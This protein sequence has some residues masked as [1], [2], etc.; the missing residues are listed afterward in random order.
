[1]EAYQYQPLPR[2]TIGR[3]APQY[4]RLMTLLPGS[5]TDSI[6][7]SLEIVDIENAPPFEALSYV[8]GRDP[9]NTPVL[10]DHKPIHTKWNLE[11]ALRNLRCRNKSR[12]LWID[13]VC[14]DQGSLSERSRQV[15]YMSKIYKNASGV[16]VWLG[17]KKL[18]VEQAFEFASHLVQLQSQ[19]FS[20]PGAAYVK[21]DQD[22]T[23]RYHPDSFP[24]MMAEL[25]SK[26][27]LTGYLIDIFAREYFERVWCIQEVLSSTKCTAKCEDLEMDF[28]ELVEV[29]LYV[30][31]FKELNAQS[32]W[33]LFSRQFWTAVSGMRPRQTS[34]LFSQTV[35]GSSGALLDLLLGTRDFKSTDP[36]DKVYALLGISDEGLRPAFAETRG[37]GVE[38]TWFTAFRKVR[39]WGMEQID[40]LYPSSGLISRA[41]LVPD[42]EK[43][44]KEVY[45]N[46]TSYFIDQGDRILDVLS[47]VQHSEDPERN[48]F[49]SWV[50]DW[51]K[52]RSVSIMAEKGF[53]VG[54]CRKARM[55]FDAEVYIDRDDPDFIGLNGFPLDEVEKV[56]DILRFTPSDPLP[57]EEIWRNLFDLPLFP[58]PNLRYR[59]TDERLDHAFFMTLNLSPMG[60][61]NTAIY[62][63]A[64]TDDPGKHGLDICARHIKENCAAWLDQN[65][66]A[67]L[68]MYPDLTSH[69]RETKG[70]ASS[71]VR[72]AA[73]FCTNRRFF[74]TKTGYLGIGPSVIRA[75]DHVCVLF[76]GR[77]PFVLRSSGK[78][79]LLI[80]EAYLYD[81]ELLRGETVEAVRS[82]TSGFKVQMYGLK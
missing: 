45:R 70:S 8:W 77:L 57:A 43:S 64:S 20:M 74:I 46:L 41:A 3:Y 27:Q 29:S 30:Q 69:G 63:L 6:R 59:N 78:Y 14:I 2:V 25:D 26:P 52:P 39:A 7:C 54:V 50:P 60:G 53:W 55:G 44:V 82:G 81:E 51:S 33:P 42:Y 66:A 34:S 62:E 67:N 76:G 48:S 11:Q 4:T 23:R 38:K 35:P 19:L 9:S 56:S 72:Q 79:N 40:S 17:V 71:F 15:A 5:H 22:E 73:A 47:H 21:E 58:R 65:T 16:I 75:G 32:A 31:E 80:G 61:F 18:G 10:C 1:M 12:L 28:F 49:P 24:R 68:P 37:K 13:A 36:R